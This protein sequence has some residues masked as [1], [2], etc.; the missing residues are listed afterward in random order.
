MI[1]EEPQK[2]YGL[3]TA[4]SL[5]VGVCIG[6]G[7]FFKSDNILVLT[8]GNVQQSIW[9]FLIAAFCV[10]TGSITIGQL[11][12]RTEEAGGV[13]AYFEDFVSR[14]FGSGFGWFYLFVYYPTITAV[15]PWVA[16]IY[17]LQLFNIRGSLELQILI[18]AIYLVFAFAMNYLSLV[19]AG[20]FQNLATI[21]KLIPLI[22][23]GIIS[24]FWNEPTATV[25]L[26]HEM[27][28]H[29]PSTFG[30]LSALTPMAFSFEGWIVAT[31]ISHEVK[32][33]KRSMPIALFVGPLVVLAIYLTYFLGLVKIVGAPQILALGDGVV[34]AVGQALLGPVGDKVLTFFVLLAVLGVVNGMTLSFIR[35]PQA[36]ALRGMIPYSEKVKQ[37]NFERGL[38][39]ASTLFAMVLSFVWLTIHYFVQKFHLLG[40]S[41]VSE[42]AIIFSY[43]GYVVLYVKVIQM[44]KEGKINNP[45]L[46]KIIPVFAIF[47]SIVIIIGGYIAS[48]TYVPFF[49]LFCLVVCYLGYR[50]DKRKLAQK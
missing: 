18:A 35:M 24:L 28:S 27:A 40:A 1:M 36:L 5:I 39:P 33:A 20:R 19:M 46:G 41:D 4:I 10:I 16:S 50:Y 44:A 34:S 29:S 23:I 48:P 8:N 49:I 25:P 2:N 13:V 6:S 26:S 17:T 38:S 15:V 12:V 47:G 42:I 45:L 22:G 21:G 30:W 37:I 43:V 3:M 7:I 11:A 32:N 31:G 9:I 14:S